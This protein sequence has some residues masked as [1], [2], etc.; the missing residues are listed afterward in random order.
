MAK[1]T[2]GI[3]DALLTARKSC[4]SNG[5]LISFEQIRMR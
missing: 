5:F 4:A 2:I 3:R 1:L